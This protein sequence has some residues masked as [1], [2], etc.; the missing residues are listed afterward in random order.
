MLNCS[1]ISLLI[2]GSRQYAIAFII[3]FLKLILQLSGLKQKSLGHAEAAQE[4]VDDYNDLYDVK[5]RSALIFIPF[6]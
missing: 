4:A 2:F 6:L 5:F 3:I 1:E